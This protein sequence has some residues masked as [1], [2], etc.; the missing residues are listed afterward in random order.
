MELHVSNLGRIKEAKLDI[1]PLT[2][3][4]GPNHTNKTWTAYSLYGIARDLAQIEFSTR[5][6]DL[7]QRRLGSLPSAHLQ[8]RVDIAADQLFRLL[9][10]AP[11]VE[12]KA[13]ITREEAIGGVSASDLT[14][15]HSGKDRF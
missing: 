4:I 8:S 9:T 12:R 3:F 13:R 15:S 6:P 14:P 2:V 10:K 1:R 11:S 5:Q 7:G